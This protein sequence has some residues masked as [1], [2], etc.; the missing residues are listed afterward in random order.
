[1]THDLYTCNEGRCVGLGNGPD[2]S[3]VHAVASPGMENGHL[4]LRDIPFYLL[5]VFSFTSLSL[6][7]PSLENHA[8]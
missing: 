2:T 6:F 5:V 4:A 8:T 7:C 1:M 3:S